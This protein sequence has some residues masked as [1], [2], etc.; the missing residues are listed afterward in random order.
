MSQ[1]GK[2]FL[3]TGGLGNSEKSCIS[4]IIP[5]CRSAAVSEPTPFCMDFVRISSLSLETV[6]P[7]IKRQSNISAKHLA[8][9]RYAGGFAQPL[10]D[11]IFL[12]AFHSLHAADAVIFSE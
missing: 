1:S 8:A 11:R 4:G 3:K 10:H 9:S 6:I 5:D 2:V 12:V 7:G